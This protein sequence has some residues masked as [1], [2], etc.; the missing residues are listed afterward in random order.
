MVSTGKF[1]C[2]NKARYKVVEVNLAAQTGVSKQNRETG[3]N[4]EMFKME[5]RRTIFLKGYV[6]GSVLIKKDQHS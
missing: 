5:E 6:S 2:L 3:N 4:P 1:S